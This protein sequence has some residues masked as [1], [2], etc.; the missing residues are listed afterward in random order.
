MEDIPLQLM[1]SKIKGA[2]LELDNLDFK[3]KDNN[4]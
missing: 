2:E 1:S 4:E 3:L